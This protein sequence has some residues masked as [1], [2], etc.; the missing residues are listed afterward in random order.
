MPFVRISG[1]TSSDRLSAWEPRGSVICSNK[2]ETR[3]LYLFIDEI[4]ARSSARR[5]LGGGHDERQHA[6]SVARK[7]TASTPGRVFY[8]A[9]NRPFA[10]SGL[11]DAGSIDRKGGNRRTSGTLRDL[12]SIRISADSSDA[13][14][15]RSPAD[16]GFSGAAWN[17]VNGK[18]RCWGAQNKKKSRPWFR[19][20]EDKCQGAER[21]SMI[22]SERKSELPLP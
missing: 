22:L 21:K 20:G 8:R 1:S 17:L 10:V 19:D 3:A 6:Q 9:T 2:Q 7:R 15:R 13:I 11:T 5:G 4:D 14:W 16:S 18:P 12:K